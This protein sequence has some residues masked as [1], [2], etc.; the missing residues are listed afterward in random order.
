MAE[1]ADTVGSQAQLITS[2]RSPMAYPHAVSAVDVV[3]THISWVLLTGSYAYKIKKAVKL[4]FLDFSSLEQRRH[5]CEEELQ[6]NQRWASDLYL[7]V[8]PICGSPE[9]PSVGGDGEVIE[10]AVKM[11]QFPQSAQLDRQVDAGLL[12]END[13]YSLAETVAHNHESAR[14]IEY[15][16]DRES[17]NKVSAPMLDNFAPVA[18]V[19]DME[20][21]ER[22]H[23]WTVQSLED[24]KPVLIERRK[25]GF[26][27]ECHGDLHLANLVRLQSGIVAFDC[28]EFS[29][30][31]RNIDVISDIAFLFMDLVARARQDLAAVFL[32]RYLECTGDYAGMRVFG[33]YFVYH[34]LIRAKVAAIRSDERADVV[35]RDQDIDVLKHNLAVAARWIDRRPPLLIAMH[36]YSGSGKTWLSSQLIAKLPA[37]R[38][39]SDVERKR[40]RGLDR[41]S[42]KTSMAQSGKYTQR[43]RAEVYQRLFETAEILLQEGLNVIIDASFL[44]KVDRAAAAALAERHGIPIL[45]VETHA[46]DNELMSRLKRRE[47]AGSDASEA[48]VD[49][50]RYQIASADALAE[51]EKKRTVSIATDQH[52]DA[53]A[54]V[55]RIF[56]CRI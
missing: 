38:L 11:A 10:Y 53:D 2:L 56:D 47:A 46:H 33:L 42:D 37:I 48:D 40:L 3:E 1:H 39:R 29:A 16:D 13:V 50:L 19:I 32:D 35:S 17:V 22:V 12:L 55:K 44:R 43:A 4:E 36:G 51:S 41:S 7:E 21:L 24:L 52:V 45:F 30:P 20:I 9:H 23:Q 28:V 27:R 31:L 34:C 15:A 5:F 18:K 26:V 49:I 8:V 14:I 6:L 54:V 25:A